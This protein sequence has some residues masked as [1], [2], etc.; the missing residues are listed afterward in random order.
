MSNRVKHPL[1]VAR[2]R[3]A[4]HDRRVSDVLVYHPFIQHSMEG[5]QGGEEEVSRVE[6]P[7][8]PPDQGH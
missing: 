8:G 1:E 7:P 4:L 2:P 5:G 6:G 3:E